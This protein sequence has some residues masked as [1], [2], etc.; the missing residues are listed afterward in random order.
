TDLIRDLHM[1]Q[2]VSNRKMWL[3]ITAKYFRQ[4]HRES[5]RMTG[6]TAHC[7]DELFQRQTRSLNKCQRFRGCLDACGRDHVGCDL[8]GACL[9]NRRSDLDDLFTAG[10]KDRTRFAQ[11][12][13]VPGHI[14]NELTLFGC[15][16]TPCKW[17]LEK[18][19]LGTL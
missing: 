1:F 7:L 19:R 8:D 18:P 4:F 12:R 15:R 9:A 5:C 17:S 10:F 2:H 16:F 13:I 14:I 11:C 6:V 3:K